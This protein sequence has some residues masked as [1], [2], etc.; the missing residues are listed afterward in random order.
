MTEGLERYNAWLLSERDPW[1]ENLALCLHPWETGT[2]N[3]PAFDPLIDSTRAFIE[4][5]GISV[6]TL[7]RADTAHV[8]G[9]HRPTD[10]DYFAYFGLL[11]L[12]KAHGYG[13]RAIIERSPFLLQDV[14][15]NGL[16]SAS[17]QSLADL[18]QELSDL[19]LPDISPA[20]LREKADRNQAHADAVAAAIR[21][22]FWAEDAGFFYSYDSRAGGLLRTPTVSG[23][24]PLM[25]GI[26]LPGQAAR[27][28]EHL[29]D[30]QEFWTSVPVPS[31]SPGSPAF[32]PVRYW[33][34][35]SWP[36]TNWLILH[37]LRERGLPLAEEL[38]LRTMAM[39]AEG[40]ASDAARE[41]AI[42]VLDQN[43]IGEEFTTPSRKQYAHAWLWDSAIV[44]VSWPLVSQKP[45]PHN[46]QVDKP[47]F[48]EYYH[49]QTGEPLGAP[50]MS[51]TASLFIELDDMAA[52]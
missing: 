36:V 33:S 17:F 34:G 29:S 23:F 38:R 6:D 46:S 51:W 39:I 22:K 31:T 5:Q 19:P 9:A 10:R 32:N 40:A 47:R 18:Q 27:L 13:Q 37:G 2:D 4:E 44:A 12:F 15:F 45:K 16:L 42:Q 52:E 3:S 30:P 1:G 20:A 7:G 11:A 49:P 26:A 28:L 41:A 24:M 48:W 21:R 35:P 50:L 8:K 43:S 25:A 14:L